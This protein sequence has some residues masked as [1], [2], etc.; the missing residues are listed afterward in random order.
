MD[1]YTKYLWSFKI[2]NKSALQVKECRKFIY[3]NFGVPVAIQP[4]NGKEF[5]NRLLLDY[6]RDLNV[7]VIMGGQ[8]IPDLRDRS[9]EQ[10]RP[11]KGVG[12]GFEWGAGKKVDR[13]FTNSCP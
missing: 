13:F 1:T 12:K 5:R 4:D 11:L 7:R 9:K 2:I 3:M 8:D 10:T 6:N